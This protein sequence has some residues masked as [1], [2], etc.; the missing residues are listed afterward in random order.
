MEFEHRKGFAVIVIPGKDF[1]TE[2]CRFCRMIN[3]SMLS[4]GGY[5][6]FAERP[7]TY[8][9]VHLQVGEVFHLEVDGVHEAGEVT[10]CVSLMRPVEK[11]MGLMKIGDLQIVTRH[12]SR[13]IIP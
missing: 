9:D 7:E 6:A 8:L 13:S 3:L 5:P 1:P 2:E 12:D 11:D 4:I 10:A